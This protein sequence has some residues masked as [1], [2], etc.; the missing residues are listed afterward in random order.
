MEIPTCQKCGNLLQAWELRGGGLCST[1]IFKYH[2]KWQRI[3]HEY[4]KRIQAL[5]YERDTKYA[6]LEEEY[7]GKGVSQSETN[8]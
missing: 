2:Q 8:C 4:Y 7:L 5:L 1:C 3:R 6:E